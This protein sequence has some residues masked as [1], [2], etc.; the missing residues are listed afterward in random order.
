VKRRSAQI[1]QVKP[2]VFPVKNARNS[3]CTLAFSKSFTL[4]RS[5]CL[6]EATIESLTSKSARGKRYKTGG[7][8]HF[9]GFQPP[10]KFL[11]SLPPVFRA[12]KQIPKAGTLRVAPAFAGAAAKT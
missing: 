12:R 10:K 11:G 1:F 7:R 3:F 5:I 4:N 9:F 2:H 8:P 6:K